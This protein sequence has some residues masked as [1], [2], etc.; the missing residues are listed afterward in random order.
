MG[1]NG[2]RVTSNGGHTLLWADLGGILSKL[3]K[4]HNYGIWRCL[5]QNSDKHIG[6]TKLPIFI[7]LGLFRQS[8]QH[9]GRRLNEHALKT[10]RYPSPPNARVLTMW[11]TMPTFSY[12]YFNFARTTTGFP[13]PLKNLHPFS[14]AVNG[15]EQS[16]QD[17]APA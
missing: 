11:A 12:A 2:L 10:A 9:L 6:S 13:Y 8:F 7:M 3:A 14:T 4:R 5:P 1:Y 16:R 17:T 15:T